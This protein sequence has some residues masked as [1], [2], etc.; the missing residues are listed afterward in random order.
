MLDIDGVLNSIYSGTMFICGNPDN[1]DYNPECLRNVKRIIEHTGCEILWITS[2]RSHPD[3]GYFTYEDKNYFN[4]LPKINRILKNY[5]R[6]ER[7]PHLLKS[8]KYSDISYWL[9][10]KGYTDKMD[11]NET[12][13]CKFAI[14]DDD[15]RQHLDLYGKH[16]FHIDNRTGLTKEVAD[17]VIKFLN[18]GIRE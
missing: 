18:E 16:W 7:C 9:L 3:N 5:T 14:L 4:L 2:W 13:K 15:D 12:S 11:Q 8:T 1:Y 6:C 17:Q 10:T